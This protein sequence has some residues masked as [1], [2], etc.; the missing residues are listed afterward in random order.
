LSNHL[1]PEHPKIV[2]LDQQISMG[3]K[4][5]QY[6]SSQSND[7]LVAAKQNAK[8]KIER[9]QETIKEWE[10]KVNNASE[11]IAECERLKLNVERIQQLHDHLLA[12][13]QTVDVGKNLDQENI[14]ILERPREAEDARRIG[15][16]TAFL[17]FVGLGAGLG[18]VHLVEQ[19]DDRIRSLEELNGRFDEWVVGQVPEVPRL[20]KRKIPPLLTMN[21]NRHAFAESHRSLRSALWFAPDQQEKPKTLL[22]TSA[23]P[24][25][26]KSTLA[27]NLARTMS[28][29]GSR[30]LLIDADLRRGLL[31]ELFEVPTQPGLSDLLSNGTADL[32]KFVREISLTPMPACEND[33]VSAINTGSLHLLPRGRSVVN[34]GELFLGPN[35]DHLLEHA[36]K[37]FDIVILDSIPVFAADDTSSLAPKVDGIIFVMR[38]SFTSTDTARHALQLLYERQAKVL[39][40]VFNRANSHARSYN[41]YKYASYCHGRKGGGKS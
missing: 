33:S 4:L 16:V 34:S 36:R 40:L 21:D 27:A 14:T 37:V 39:G 13:L 26:G 20:K 31:H 35:C 2:I 28:F 17:L 24:S 19:S 5:V 22:I 7:Q 9:V 41:Y 29:A 38:N 10:A 15:I 18:L 8:L 30:V 6:L 3:E 12:L 11:R 25:E 1:R 32:S 23:I